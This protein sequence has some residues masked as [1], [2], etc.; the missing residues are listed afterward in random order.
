LD[1]IF[2]RSEFEE[3]ELILNRKKP[4]KVQGRFEGY[5]SRMHPAHTQ[6]A[7]PTSIP[8]H[9]S[10]IGYCE[11]ALASV[12]GTEEQINFTGILYCLQHGSEYV[13]KCTAL[14]GELLLKLGHEAIVSCCSRPGRGRAY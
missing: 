11:S 14:S 5:E 10:I 12:L 1:E 9:K 7:D 3:Y 6:A 8:G 4:T 13:T 2:M